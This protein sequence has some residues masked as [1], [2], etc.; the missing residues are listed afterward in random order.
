MKD[1]SVLPEGLPVPV[2]DGAC[3]HLHN[4]R[5]PSVPLLTTSGRTVDLAFERGITVIYFYPLIGHPEAPPMLGWNEIP[6]ARG[7]TPQSCSYRDLIEDFKRM[8]V[9]VF[10][11]SS[12]SLDAQKEAASR[13]RLPFELLNDSAL[14]FANALALPTFQYDDMTLIKRLTLII[15]DGVVIKVYYPVFP[16]NQNAL[17]VISWLK[18][19]FGVI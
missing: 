10:G 9:Q 14:L 2:N 1:L 17:D 7:C 16:P 13:L 18:T 12:Q 3:Q 5:V 15:Q 8:G 19:Y 11:A 4:L 6:G